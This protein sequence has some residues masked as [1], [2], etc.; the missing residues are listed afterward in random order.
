MIEILYIKQIFTIHYSLN[1]IM[2]EVHDSP[3]VHAPML[4]LVVSNTIPATVLAQ[5]QLSNRVLVALAISSPD[6]S[7]DL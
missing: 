4:V 7:V 2:T 5:L 1:I 3:A 6:L